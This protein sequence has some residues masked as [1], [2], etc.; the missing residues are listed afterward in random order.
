MKS[1]QI[2]Y[3]KI[4]YGPCVFGGEVLQVLTYNKSS[5]QM[6]LPFISYTSTITCMYLFFYTR[7]VHIFIQ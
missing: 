5:V 2:L 4:M 1:L 7:K 3:I 6:F